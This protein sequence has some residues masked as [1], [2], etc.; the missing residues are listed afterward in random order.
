MAGTLR[1]T[2][3]AT[4]LNTVGR[5]KEQR[6]VPVITHLQEWI[7]SAIA[8]PTLTGTLRFTHPATLNTPQYRRTGKGATRRTRHNAP[9][10]AD[11]V[12]D[13]GTHPDGYAALYPSCNA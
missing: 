10:E 2:H 8:A 4:H 5:V 9:A 11:R 1:F 6:D 7:V 12:R 3:P 13:C